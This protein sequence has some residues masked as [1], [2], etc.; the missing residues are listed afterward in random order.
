MKPTITISFILPTVASGLE[1]DLFCVLQERVINDG[2]CMTTVCLLA[3][4]PMNAVGGFSA[5]IVSRSLGEVF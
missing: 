2:Q 5:S 4:T 3:T 1:V